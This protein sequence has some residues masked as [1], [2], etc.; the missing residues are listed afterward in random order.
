MRRFAEDQKQ[1]ILEV[2]MHIDIRND[3]DELRARWPNLDLGAG[4]QAKMPKRI[5][6]AIAAYCDRPDNH[7]GCGVKSATV[8]EVRTALRHLKSAADRATAVGTPEGRAARKLLTALHHMRDFEAMSKRARSYAGLLQRLGRQRARKAAVCEAR[9]IRLGAVD[10]LGEVCLDRLVSVAELQKTGRQLHLCVADS[11]E[12]GREYHHR[13]RK[14]E[15][16]FWKLRSGA[17]L[18]L[19]EVTRVDESSHGKIVECEMTSECEAKLPRSMYLRLARK[20]D[21]SGN[22]VAEFRDAGAFWELRHQQR[23]TATLDIGRARYRVWRFPD[24]VF[25]HG[26]AEESRGRQLGWSR[27]VRPWHYWA[28]GRPKLYQRESAAAEGELRCVKGSWAWTSTGWGA[29]ALCDQQLQ[30]LVL[31]SVEMHELLSN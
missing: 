26:G 17:P 25:I 24:E 15:A 29:R 14:K 4:F 16:E 3:M 31:R 23:P 9:S 10:A 2:Y 19:L 6:R 27:F 5:E 1:P 21:A 22:D 12:F 30:N 18:A 11:D 8:A 7:D 28:R 20:L 13:L